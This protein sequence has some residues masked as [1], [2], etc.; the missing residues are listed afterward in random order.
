[1]HGPAA[2]IP[3]VRWARLKAGDNWKISN[4]LQREAESVPASAELTKAPSATCP[5]AK[6]IRSPRRHQQPARPDGAQ[7]SSAAKSRMNT[8]GRHGGSCSSGDTT[9][10][11][12]LLAKIR[13]AKG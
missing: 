9:E 10:R 13:E 6:A 1:M 3:A 4:T 5:S 7:S 11:D 12:Q 2:T 8:A